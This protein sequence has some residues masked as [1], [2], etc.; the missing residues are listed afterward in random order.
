MIYAPEGTTFRVTRLLDRQLAAEMIADEASLME[1]IEVRGPGAAE[2]LWLA[3]RNGEFVPAP[4]DGI[5]APLT[6]LAEIALRSWLAWE[7]WFNGDT[8]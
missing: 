8:P 5:A 7:R 3:A 4:D 6:A 2:N 1:M